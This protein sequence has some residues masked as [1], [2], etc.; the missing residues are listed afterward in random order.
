[1]RGPSGQQPP[2]SPQK[3]LSGLSW[4]V[5]LGGR[6]SRAFCLWRIRPPPGGS[7]FRR[8]PA[9]LNSRVFQVPPGRADS[10]ILHGSPVVSSGQ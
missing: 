4:G 1:M 10:D 2:R 6:L 7:D 5:G 9:V 3:L 8:A